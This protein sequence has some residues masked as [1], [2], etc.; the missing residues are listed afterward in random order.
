MATS[1]SVDF[2]VSRDNLITDALLE[3]GAIGIGDTASN[4]QVTHAARRLNSFVKS[5][6]A[7]G[8]SLWARKTGYILP[9]SNVN[10]IILGPSGNH[11]TLAYVQTTLSAA[12][13]SGASTISVTAVTGI[14][15]TYYIGVE[16][17]DGTMHWTTVNGAPS[18]TTVT[19]TATLTG[20]ASS[21]NYVYCYQTKI[22]RPLRILNAY[23]KDE[24]NDTE[25]EIDVVSKQ[26]FDALGAKTSEGVPNQITY[27][28]QLDNGKAYIYPRFKDGRSS[29]TI[30]FQRPFEDFDAA[31]D[32]PDFPQEW[33]EPLMLGL[34]T[35]LMGPY[36][37]PA[38]DRVELNARAKAALDLAQG[39]E[40]EEGS[41]YITPDLRGG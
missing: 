24:V 23:V 39:N 19:L 27:D 32:T 37:L 26:E 4:D 41:M 2:S 11:A 29:I 40:P 7:H 5:L 28:P 35:K 17:D 33:Y 36:G 10:E 21:G 9:Q 3:A 16:L 6:G 34:A 14:A 18:G 12:A 30:I 15:N 25:H 8:P 1:G 13:A 38:Q 22:Q 20:A 31:G